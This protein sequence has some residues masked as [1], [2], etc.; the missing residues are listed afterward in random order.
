MKPYLNTGTKP[1]GPADPSTQKPH[2]TLPEP[3]PDSSPLPY[4]PEG[5]PTTIKPQKA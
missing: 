1:P 4:L 2:N 5:V 3:P